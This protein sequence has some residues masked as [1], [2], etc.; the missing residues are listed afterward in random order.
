MK[1]SLLFSL[2]LFFT[3]VRKN[4]PASIYDIKVTA[5]KG[6]DIDLSAYKGK[7]ILIVNVP[8]LTP[9]ARQ[10]TAL[11][12]LSDKYPGKLVVIG[13]LTD[14]FDI[15]PGTKINKIDYHKM[16]YK[17]SFP[18][19]DKVSVR[20]ETM[21]PVFQWLT[22]K[23]YNGLKDS[24]VKWNFQKYLV[25]ETGHLIAVFDPKVDPLSSQVTDAIS[26]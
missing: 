8:C 23:Q 16:T 24:Y 10:Y 5:L 9:D 13:V 25:D 2:L 3:P 18:L 4:I 15:E 12:Q 26:K 22:Q 19:G 20:G 1:L 17:V 11:Q 7:K 14:N 21:A 6:N